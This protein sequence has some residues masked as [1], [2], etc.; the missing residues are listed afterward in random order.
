[1][2]VAKHKKQ[3]DIAGYV[4]YMWQIED[5]IRANDLDMLKI[6]KNI[7]SQYEQP[8]DVKKQI[9]DWYENLTL[10]MKNEKKEK[11]GH[12]QV[13][14]NTVDDMNHLHIR[15]MNSP[16]EIAYQHQ[17]MKAVPHIKE[18]EKKMQPSPKHDIEL[19]LAALY[20]AFALKLQGK[21]ITNATKEALTVFGKSLSML[22]A[23][24]REDQKGD[25]N[26]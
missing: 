24:Y 3:N 9:Y 15:L 22:S 12:L 26:L 21:D 1:M 13:L 7:I 18:L 5:I 14:I 11:S 17:F 10:M 6:E 8:D 20:N 23:K 16:K 19:M 2:I 25:L 4:L